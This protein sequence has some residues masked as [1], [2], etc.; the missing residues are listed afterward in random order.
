MRRA[1]AKVHLGARDGRGQRRCSDGS[2]HAAC[3]EVACLRKAPGTQTQLSL[4]LPTRKAGQP[5]GV[6]PLLEFPFVLSQYHSQKRMAGEHSLRLPISPQ[7]ELLSPV[8]RFLVRMWKGQPDWLPLFIGL[9]YAQPRSRTTSAT[10]S[11]A[12]RYAAKRLCT[13]RFWAASWTW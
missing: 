2:V 8:S 3:A 5:P 11:T 7:E 9:R 10:R 13:L 12:T 1:C 6:C 4:K